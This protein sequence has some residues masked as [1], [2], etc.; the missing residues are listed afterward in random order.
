[1]L[2]WNHV[3]SGILRKSKIFRLFLKDSKSE[4]PTRKIAVCENKLRNCISVTFT[5]TT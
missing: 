2:K 3:I 1:M 4:F 5:K